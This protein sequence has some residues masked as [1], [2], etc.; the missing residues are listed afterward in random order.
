M[1]VRGTPDTSQIKNVEAKSPKNA[2][3]SATKRLKRGYPGE[4]MVLYRIAVTNYLLSDQKRKALK[5]LE[6]G[7]HNL[8]AYA[9][10]YWAGCLLDS[11]K[12]VMRERLDD[13]EYRA[14]IKRLVETMINAIRF[15][16]M[17]TLYMMEESYIWV[18]H[19]QPHLVRRMDRFTERGK[20]RLREI[21]SKIRE[22]L[23]ELGEFGEDLSPYLERVR[24]LIE[25]TFYLLAD[26][27]FKLEL[28]SMFEGF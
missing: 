8:R 12:P 13:N 11:L 23:L 26:Y 18:H 19:E 1:R 16:I 28:K 20:E 25:R 22:L 15:E 24:E 4:A 3:I 17:R 21:F 27:P 14:Y 2:M 7:Y 9:G 5:A 6:R 10:D